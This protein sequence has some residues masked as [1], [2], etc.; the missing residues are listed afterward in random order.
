[1]H[2]QHVHPVAAGI[3]HHHAGRIKAHRLV[4]QHAAIPGGRIVRAQPERVIGR[5]GKGGGMGFAEPVRGKARQ[6]R[7]DG[8]R[9]GGIDALG[10]RPLHKALTEAGHLRLGAV[11]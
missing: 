3:A 4:V 6:L 11:A 10:D 7:K 8:I 9:G 5:L 1:M 2:R